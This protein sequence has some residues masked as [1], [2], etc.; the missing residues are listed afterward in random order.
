MR[1]LIVIPARLASVRLPRKVLLAETGKPLIQHVIE[2]ANEC[3]ACND[4]APRV[5]VEGGGDDP[6]W[7]INSAVEDLRCCLRTTGK[8][9][10][11]TSRAG[12]TLA[13]EFTRGLQW[14]AICVVQCDVPE[15]SPALI[16][17]VIESLERHPEW[18]CATAAYRCDG[19][20][21]Q[22]RV[23]A[24]MLQ[25]EIDS[26]YGIARDFSR[27]A[28]SDFIHIGIYC[29]RRDAL[30]KYAAAGP[31][32]REQD[33]S[34]EQLRALHIGLKMGVVLTE[35]APAGIDTPEDYAAFVARWKASHA[36]SA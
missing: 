32:E 13:A 25:S 33:E 18:D 5:A 34:L 12:A 22:N 36:D 14:D 11:G 9:P 27:L 1:T 20:G 3:K 7:E 26:S 21:N 6:Q 17:Q 24:L 15:I 8:H 2:Q 31:C 28:D 23:K 16:D 19:S 30:L 4:Y 35:H 10:S 29:Y